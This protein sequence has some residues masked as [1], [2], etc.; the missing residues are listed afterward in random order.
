V[1]SGY[2]GR[3]EGFWISFFKTGMIFCL[4]VCLFV[5]LYLVVIVVLYV[6][7]GGV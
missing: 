7:L 5:C 1:G 2:E 4:F 3:H 6:G